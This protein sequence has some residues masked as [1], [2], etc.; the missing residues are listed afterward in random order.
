MPFPEFTDEKPKAE[1][2]Q[3]NCQSHRASEE[4][5]LGV[6][7]SAPLPASPLGCCTPPGRG[8]DG[9]D[10][11][12]TFVSVPSMPLFKSGRPMSEISGKLKTSGRSERLE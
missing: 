3:V 7:I 1:K 10:L 6:T 5:S 8:K 4:W 2:T 12:L 11:A 9:S